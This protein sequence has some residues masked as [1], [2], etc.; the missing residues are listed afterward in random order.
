VSK[1]SREQIDFAIAALF[2][3]GD[4]VE[5]RIP[6][7]GRFKT[8]SGYFDDFGKLAE[9]I[10]MHSGN[11][12]G[13]YY[14]LNPVN[15]ALLARA[16]NNAKEFA[17]A[18]TNDRDVVRRCWLLIDIDPVRPAGVSSSDP[19]KDA[20]KAKARAVRAWLAERGWPA[21]LPADSGNGYHL[22]YR[23]DLENNEESTALIKSCLAA[24]ASKFDDDTIKIDT[25][26]YNAARIVKAYGSMAAKGDS[27]E[28]RPHRIAHLMIRPERL[29]AVTIVRPE[30]LQALAGEAPTKEP[31]RKQQKANA[32]FTKITAEKLEEFLDYHK[33][34]HGPRMAY[35]GGFKWQLEEC[36]FNAE[37][38][39]PDSVVYLFDD[40]PRFKCSHN[41]CDE[42]HWTEFRARLEE[43][44]HELP[45]FY[46]FERETSDR[47]KG[48]GAEEVGI[49]DGPASAGGSDSRSTWNELADELDV[50]RIGEEEYEDAQGKTKK[51]KLP[52]HIAEE[53][54]YRFV[55]RAFEQRSRFFFDAYPYVY[56]PDEETI[57]K[58]HNDDEAHALLGRMRLRIEQHD[59]KLCRSNLELHILAKG[60]ETRVE[61]YGCWRGEYIYV[62]NGRGGMF[63]IGIRQISDVPN[64]TDG[65]LMLAPEVQPWPELNAENQVKMRAI[66]KK[67]G[68]VGLKVAEDSALCRHLN[69][70]FETQGLAPE[71]YQQLFISRYL[72]LFLGGPHL[73]LRPIL[74]ALGEQNSGKST[75]FEKLMWLLVG[76]AYESEALPGD[77]RSFVAAVTNNQ[78]KIFDNV[79]GSDAEE[80]GYVDVMCKCA[81][82]GRIPIAQLYATNVERMF[83]LRCDLMFTARYNPFPSHRS[84][85]SRRTLFFP[86]RRPTTEEYRTVEL[87]QKDLMA[88]ADEMKLETLIR[89]R[90]VL[91]GLL[92]NKDTEYPPV[93]EMHS[94]E[95]FTMRCADHEGWAGEME[96]IWRGYRGDYQQRIAEYAPI[97]DEVRKW[98]GFKSPSTPSAPPVFPNAGR[99]VKVSELWQELREIAGLDLT[100]KNASTLGRALERHLSALR[101]LGVERKMLNGSWRYRFIPIEKQMEECAGAWEDA[102]GCGYFGPKSDRQAV[103]VGI[104]PDDVF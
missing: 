30:M 70:L 19:E 83:E 86:I 88:D 34:G 12:E 24:L 14:T 29:E 84:D 13:I 46:F 63:K 23:I 27:T 42:N 10:E 33:V 102:R 62:N 73:K 58:F 101:V 40:G 91:R 64:G 99:W 85:L 6:K 55:L 67:L 68:V 104:D 28:D 43:L 96:Q 103:P 1:A 59:T 31:Q 78:V 9:A 79:D 22:L 53:R 81:S 89:L 38:H 97:V 47:A 49:M 44:N 93:S 11:F 8:I 5:L 69:A 87:M 54:V 16:N 72:S 75:L 48:P 60:Q 92:A 71:Q 52:K 98:V 39:T 41:S 56:L 32:S 74:M 4:V 94:Y 95:T 36:P 37:H 26:V 65:V 82:G 51:K 100:W 80:L 2:R 3:P 77:M 25:T 45:K 18:T 7:A 90:N 61:K 57:F 66:S 76:P 21:P 15:P 50:I 17:Q 20:A 35:E